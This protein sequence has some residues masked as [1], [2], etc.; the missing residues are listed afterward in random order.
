M[1]LIPDCIEQMVAL[2]FKLLAIM[3]ENFGT[4][5][6]FEI[7]DIWGGY[8]GWVCLR[9]LIGYSASSKAK[10]TSGRRHK[11]EEG[12][13][14]ASRELDWNWGSCLQRCCVNIWFFI[15]L[16]RTSDCK[17]LYA[18][19]YVAWCWIESDRVWCTLASGFIQVR[20][21]VELSMVRAKGT[22]SCYQTITVIIVVNRYFSRIDQ[23]A[24]ACNTQE[25]EV[26]GKLDGSWA[27]QV[28]SGEFFR[29]EIAGHS[30]L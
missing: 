3:I 4:V 9:T 6:I 13:H 26:Y 22:Q 30:R 29:L 23:V 10:K 20:S 19:Q 8:V 15:R 17:R 11:W 27:T 1:M 24:I 21:V 5:F 12:F 14:N 7:D 16:S 2:L 18:H 25:H 28:H